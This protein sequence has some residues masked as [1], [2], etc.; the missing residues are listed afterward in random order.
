MQDVVSIVAEFQ[1]K[2]ADEHVTNSN[3][4]HSNNEKDEADD[5]FGDYVDAT[6]QP[7]HS[8]QHEHHDSNFYQDI[9]WDFL[10]EK[11]ATTKTKSNK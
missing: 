1:A 9:N 4:K 2:S 5:E 11:P 3:D 7:H 10:A 8:H 6:G